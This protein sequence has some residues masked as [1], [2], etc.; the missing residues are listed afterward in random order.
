MTNSNLR[1]FGVLAGAYKSNNP[2]SLLT[3]ACETEDGEYGQPRKVLCNR[4][5]IDNLVDPYGAEDHG[6]APTC[7][8]CLRKWNKL[9]GV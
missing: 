8:T 6:V 5:D 4:V 3:H 2:K 1:S 9:H 7:P